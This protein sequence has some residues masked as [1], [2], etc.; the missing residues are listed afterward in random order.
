MLLNVSFFCCFFF[1]SQKID[2]NHA[3]PNS[4]ILEGFQKKVC[5]AHCNGR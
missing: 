2:S 4:E 1:L 3:A 5:I